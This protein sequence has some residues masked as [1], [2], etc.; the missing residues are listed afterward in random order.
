MFRKPTQIFFL[1][2]ILHGLSFSV[3]A[4]SALVPEGV[5]GDYLYIPFDVDIALD[6][7]L[8]DW[9]NIPAYTVTKGSQL[10][11]DPAENGSFTF[12]VAADAE[13]FYITMQMPDQNIIAGQHGNDFWNED[14]FEFY[15][16]FTGEFGAKGYKD[17]IHQIN[18]NATNIGND[19]P[20]DVSISGVRSGSLDVQALVFATDDGWGFEG[21]AA[22]PPDFVLEHGAE[23]GF[24]AQINGATQSDRNVKLIWSNAD[25]ADGSWQDPSLFGRGI[26]YEIGQTDAPLPSEPE[27]VEFDPGDV[28]WSGLVAAT[29]DGY[30]ANY[31]Y[32][33]EN[34]GDNLG[35]VFDPNMDYQAVSEGIGYGMLMAV[36]M[37][38]QATFDIIY[39]AAHD[40]MLD[41]ATGLFHWKADNSG[42]LTGLTSATDAEVDIAAALIFAQQLVDAGT[43]SQHGQRPYDERAH[44]LIDSIYQYEVFDGQYLTP[45]DDWQG[46]GQEIINLSYFAP[47]WFRIFDEFQGTDRWVDVIRQG[48]ISLYN[49]RGGSRYGL[50]PDWSTHDGKPAF[51]Y[52][53]RTNRPLDTCKFEM[54]FDAIRVPWRIGLDCLWFGEARACLWSQRS[55]EF[56]NGLSATDFARMYDMDGQS[57]VGYQ[58]ELMTGM[59]L[60]AAMA[61]EDGELQTRLAEMLYN[62][63]S[64]ALSEGYWGGTSQYYFNQSLAWFGASLL[65]GDFRNLTE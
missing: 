19:D 52:C 63:S 42:N 37:D 53:E 62:Q 58:N 41:E 15:L 34:C 39:D 33:G 35:L 28:D 36:M 18:I 46:N 6:G 17:G 14:S 5:A 2:I 57:V 22:L 27:V 8:D 55:A 12:A 20:S 40:I 3:L 38:D 51:D 9:A 1:L 29:W 30:K 26:F 10:S 65:S 21:S 11:P 48:Y 64:N 47:A 25:A 60:V 7:S 43:W 49:V 59:W 23:I 13:R 56:L 44:A 32:C 45:G 54:T 50:A 31:I 24:Q 16:N 61:A 4:Q